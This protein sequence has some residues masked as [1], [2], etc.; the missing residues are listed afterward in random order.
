VSFSLG[1]FGLGHLDKVRLGFIRVGHYEFKLEQV[2][3]PKRL[4]FDIAQL[5]CHQTQRRILSRAVTDTKKKHQLDE[6]VRNG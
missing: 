2:R 3:R 1:F 6:K 4:A 5:S